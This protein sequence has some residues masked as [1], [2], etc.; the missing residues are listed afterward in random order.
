M[1]C[2]EFSMRDPEASLVASALAFS[3][4]EI[5]VVIADSIVSQPLSKGISDLALE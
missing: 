5:I 2:I 4:E 1:G 3:S